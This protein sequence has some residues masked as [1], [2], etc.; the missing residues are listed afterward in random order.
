MSVDAA[1][2]TEMMRRSGQM[3]VP[4]ITVGPE[5]VVGFD[6]GRLTALLAAGARKKASLG[7][8]IADAAGK[9]ISQAPAGAFVGRV[10]GSSVAERA[11]IQAGDVIVEANGRAVTTAADLE[12]L[13]RE[14]PA[15]SP[16][17]LTVVRGGAS[18][19]LQPRL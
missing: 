14:L 17:R 9:G 1:G 16:L 11:G 18:L 12:R 6:Q 7:I 19:R 2:R 3:G 5:V 15:G 13:L 8:H 10:A 4:V